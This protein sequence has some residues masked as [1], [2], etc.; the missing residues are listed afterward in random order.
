MPSRRSIIVGAALL[1]GGV[2]LGVLASGGTAD[3]AAERPRPANPTVVD[4]RAAT[5]A[6][7]AAAKLSANG[8][9]RAPGGKQ[10]LRP[11]ISRR[12]IRTTPGDGDFVGLK[13]PQGF[14]AIS[15]GA[16]TGFIN[17]VISQSTPIHPETGRYTP[18]T[19]W[20]AVTNF[21]PPPPEGEALEW[22]PLVNCLNKIKVMR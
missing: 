7:V 12:P 2:A 21:E 6:E 22:T 16:L 10:T 1:A 3:P 5:R 17:L 4:T 9:K 13:C 8:A 11:L 18:R 14:V 15:G 20:V 19:W